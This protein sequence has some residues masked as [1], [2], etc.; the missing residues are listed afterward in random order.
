MYQFYPK[1]S[2]TNEKVNTI[3]ISPVTL[4]SE[5][6]VALNKRNA[7]QGSVFCVWLFLC[8]D[9]MS[10]V[11]RKSYFRLNVIYRLQSNV[12]H[13]CR[14]S[15]HNFNI[16]LILAKY[17]IMINLQKFKFVQEFTFAIN[18]ECLHSSLQ[19]KLLM[20]N[21]AHAK[22]AKTCFYHIKYSDSSVE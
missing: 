6:D 20:H 21:C 8:N 13:I 11:V 10:L 9:S 2:K 16:P 5:Y 7:C 4:T 1:I 12:Q 17:N 15:R 14:R 19:V 3:F 22:H 18:V